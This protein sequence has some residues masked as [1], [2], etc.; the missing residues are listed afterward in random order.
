MVALEPE[1]IPRCLT[2]RIYSR[3]CIVIRFGR[4][5]KV[6]R[7]ACRY[8]S[9]S[10][11]MRR[12]A[13]CRNERA[14]ISQVKLHVAFCVFFS[15]FASALTVESSLFSLLNLR[16]GTI[17]F[18]AVH[19]LC[20]ARTATL[21]GFVCSCAETEILKILRSRCRAEREAACFQV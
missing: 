5:V 18:A 2:P 21:W 17:R 14:A 13:A 20:S 4:T 16:Y 19:S 6:F 9:D 15:F 10:D 1:C 8:S 7:G 11:E 12:I 3:E